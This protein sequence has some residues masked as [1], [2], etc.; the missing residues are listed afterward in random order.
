MPD[1]ALTL[2]VG[3]ARSLGDLRERVVFIGGAVA[4]L[5]QTDPPFSG[6]RP[7]TDV[8]AI[9]ATVSY[10]DFAHFQDE[11]RARGFRE[12]MSA[13][14]AHQWLAPGDP[15]IRFDLV[16][17]GSHLGASGNP[18]DE[19]ALRTAERLEIEPGVVIRHASAPGFLALKLAAFRDRGEDDPF[20]SHDL[21]DILALL[22]SRPGIV[23]ETAAAPADLHTFIAAR[24]ELLVRREDLDD[25]VAGHLG[26]VDRRRA[27]EAIT[28]AH[29]SLAALAA[30]RP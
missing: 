24:A 17:A 20:V 15:P 23:A 27:A 22:A 25:L 2:L 7:T 8:D 18:F 21:E 6:A 9:A 11:L 3:V 29:R 13:P 4:P 28:R 30:L 10:S 12:N 14:H 26:N 5:L 1:P 16:P 19:A